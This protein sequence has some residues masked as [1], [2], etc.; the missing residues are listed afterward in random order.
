[1]WRNNI[2]LRQCSEP[3]PVWTVQVSSQLTR[4]GHITTDTGSKSAI[5][6]QLRR[7]VLQTDSADFIAGAAPSTEM[8]KKLPAIHAAVPMNR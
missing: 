4:T 3:Q 1:M 8:E 6:Y 7:A 5:K 2:Q